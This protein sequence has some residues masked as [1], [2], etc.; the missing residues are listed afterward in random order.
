M[1][2]W[3]LLCCTPKQQ[4][5]CSMGTISSY[6][7]A[8]ALADLGDVSA[9]EA[10]GVL[11]QQVHLHVGGHRGLAQHRLE[12]LPPGALVRQGDVDE[13]IQAP[14]P[15]QSAVDNV[16]PAQHKQQLAPCPRPHPTSSQKLAGMR[17][18]PHRH[19]LWPGRLCHGTPRD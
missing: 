18:P 12:D 11:D 19:P 7:L 6:P 8:G 15:Q 17:C 13:L 14:R 3:R 2:S 5:Q 4:S 1:E 10:V 16:G 9:R